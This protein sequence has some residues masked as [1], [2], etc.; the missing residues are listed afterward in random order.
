MQTPA[1]AGLGP[2]QDGKLCSVRTITIGQYAII[3]LIKTTKWLNNNAYERRKRCKRIKRNENLINTF[4][5]RPNK[6][7]IL[8][9]QPIFAPNSSFLYLTNDIYNKINKN[10]FNRNINITRTKTVQNPNEH[11]DIKTQNLICVWFNVRD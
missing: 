6:K 3:F 2:D 11:Q 9:N 10:L 7:K 1:K 8:D 4:C 5:N